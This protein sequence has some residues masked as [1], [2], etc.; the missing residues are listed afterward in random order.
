[1]ILWTITNGVA[2]DHTKPL[3][4]TEA[5]IKAEVEAMGLDDEPIFE[6]GMTQLQRAR[7][8][9]AIANKVLVQRTN[10]DRFWKEFHESI[11]KR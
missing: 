2:T 1:M 9:K 8:V 6:E 7:A 5:Q 10:E 3:R 4:M 11:K